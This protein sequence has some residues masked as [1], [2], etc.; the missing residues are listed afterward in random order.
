MVARQA[1][2]LQVLPFFKAFMDSFPGYLTVLNEH[3][4]IVFANQ[5]FR[6]AFGPEGEDFLGLRP[7]EILG[8]VHSEE[9]SWGCGTSEFCLRCGALRTILESLEGGEWSEECRIL[10]D[11]G[12]GLEALNLRVWGSPFTWEGERFVIFSIQDISGEA[13]RKTLE[14]VFFGEILEKAASLRERAGELA[15]PSG[16]P[17][18]VEEAARRLREEAEEL[19]GEIL[20]WRNLSLAERGGLDLHLEEVRAGEVLEEVR[21]RLERRYPGAGGRIRLEGGGEEISLVTDPV[22]LERALF[23]L[24]RN[25]LEARPQGGEVVLAVREDGREVVFSIHNPGEMSREVQAQVFRRG[26]SSKGEDRGTGTYEAKLFVENFLGGDLSFRSGREE[27]TTFQVRLSR[28]R[29]EPGQ[30][31]SRNS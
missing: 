12:N 17:A 14:R 1:R 3:R 2:A 28:K 19:E 25:A 8:C 31:P 26:F 30:A 9:T 20:A 13:R 10:R 21:E 15:C 7:G 11:E 4:Q 29:A 5:A 22:L 27:G 6:K 18:E 24:A 16:L 23:D